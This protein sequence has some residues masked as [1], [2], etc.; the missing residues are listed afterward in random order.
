LTVAAVAENH[1]KMGF[2]AGGDSGQERIGG[3]S[4]EE[5]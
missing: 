3:Y 5:L 4:H 2:G 1:I